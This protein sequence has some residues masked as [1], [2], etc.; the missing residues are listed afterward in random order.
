MKTASS[1]LDISTAGSTDQSRRRMVE[2]STA[3]KSLLIH[4]CVAPDEPAVF[5]EQ[6]FAVMR[7]LGSVSDANGTPFGF[8]D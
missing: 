1:E 2:L 4:Q 7:S 3:L 6:Y 8:G 5:K